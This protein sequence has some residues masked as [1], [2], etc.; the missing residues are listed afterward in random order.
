MMIGDMRRIL[1]VCD[2]RWELFMEVL[3]NDWPVKMVD[4]LNR[5]VGVKRHVSVH[6]LT[7]LL[8][9]DKRAA[10]FKNSS[11]SSFDLRIRL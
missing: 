5:T 7:K 1:G 11:Q 2:M 3:S 4:L 8:D 9:Q 6:W 10:K